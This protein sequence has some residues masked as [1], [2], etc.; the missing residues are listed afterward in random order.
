MPAYSLMHTSF[1]NISCICR[2]TVCLVRLPYEFFMRT[3]FTL[4]SFVPTFC[5]CRYLLCVAMGHNAAVTSF[6]ADSR[7]FSAVGPVGMLMPFGLLM[8]LG[9]NESPWREQTCVPH[10]EKDARRVYSTFGTLQG[11]SV[12]WDVTSRVRWKFN[13]VQFQPETLF[14]YKRNPEDGRSRT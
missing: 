10:G 13:S 7:R 2:N 11:D 8:Q 5:S 1:R 9:R 12:I 6:S 3:Y 14:R 4:F